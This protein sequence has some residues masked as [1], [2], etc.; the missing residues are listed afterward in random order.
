MGKVDILIVQGKSN[1]RS[2]GRS[3]TWVCLKSIGRLSEPIVESVISQTK[4]PLWESLE[5]LGETQTHITSF[6]L[7]CFP[8]LM[9]AV[10]GA[11]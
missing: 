1:Q 6:S 2:R 5:F 7:H 4:L 11:L 9:Q 3:H 10:G 8:N